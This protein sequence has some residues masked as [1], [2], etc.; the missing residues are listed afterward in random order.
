MSMIGFA[1][2][3]GTAVLPMWWMDTQFSP[4]ARRSRAA[5]AAYISGQA[6]S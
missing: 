6:G 2:S 1:A 5:S 3:P 4:S